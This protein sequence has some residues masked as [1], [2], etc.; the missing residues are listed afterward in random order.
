MGESIKIADMARDLIRLSGKESDEDIEIKFT[1]LRQGEKLYEELI[2]E[3][4]GIVRTDHEK[5]MVL[6]ANGHWNGHG[7]QEAYHTWLM[8]RLSELYKVASDHDICA[9]REK[10]QTIV[11][12][13]KVQDSRCV[14]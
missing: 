1:G 11:P 5:I 6:K 14:L 2:T 10:M 13:F 9:I 7:T 8:A 3:G 12:E 4:E